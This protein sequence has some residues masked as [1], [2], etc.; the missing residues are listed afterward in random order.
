MKEVLSIHVLCT[1]T[2]TVHGGF[3]DAAM[4]YFEGTAE[5]AYFR[6][7]VLEGGCDTQRITDGQLRL[8]ARYILEGTDAEG[9][10]CRVFVE[11]NGTA[12]GQPSDGL[13]RTQPILLTDSPA[14]RWLEKAKLTG[15]AEG[16]GEDRVHIRIYAE[17][18]A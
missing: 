15:T 12:S 11:N 7:R 9:R 1:Q 3:G 18:R 13:L 17:D 4:V 10:N 2:Q 16:E 6:G 14:L 8:P 5:S